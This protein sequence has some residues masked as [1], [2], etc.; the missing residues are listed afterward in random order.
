MKNSLLKNSITAATVVMVL[1]AGAAPKFN[2][3][4]VSNRVSS[5][6]KTLSAAGMEGIVKH[7]PGLP[8]KSNMPSALSSI[9][10]ST[11]PQM[12]KMGT[13]ADSN[14]NEEVLIYENF[15]LWTE[16]TEENPIFIGDIDGFYI[17]DTY[18]NINPEKM[19][20]GKIW[21][22]YGPCSAGGVCALAYPGVGGMIQIPMGNYSGELHISVRVK[23]IDNEFT[24]DEEDGLFTIAMC[25]A[26]W[27]NPQ[28]VP[29]TE[30]S[31]YYVDWEFIEK[32]GEWHEIEWTYM[33]SYNEDDCFMQFSTYSQMLIDDIKVTVN[34]NF[35]SMPNPLPASNFTLDGFTA[36]WSAAKNATEYLLTC[37]RDVAE[38]NEPGSMMCDFEGVN[39]T[40]GAI[41]LEDPNFPKGWEFDFNGATPR[42]LTPSDGLDSDALCMDT[43]GQAITSPST[44]APITDAVIRLRFYGEPDEDGYYEGTLGFSGWDG[45][46]WVG[47]GSLYLDEYFIDEMVDFYDITEGLEYNGGK[48]YKIR[49]DIQELLEGSYVAIDDININ[50]LPPCEKEYVVTELPVKETSYVFTGLDPY[51]DYYYQ[52]SARNPELGIESAAPT[53]CTYA[54]GLSTPVPLPASDMDK[55]DG[56]YTA[57]WEK[58]PK[59]QE[60]MVNTYI[61]YNAPEEVANYPVLTETFAKADLGFTVENPYAF[62][63]MQFISLDDFCDNPGWVGYLCGIAD[64]AVGGV[65]YP[66][67]GFGGEIQTPWLSLAHNDGKFNVVVSACGFND[68]I[69]CVV[70]SNGEGY[71]CPLTEDYQ[72]YELKFT[73]GTNNDFLAFYTQNKENFFINYVEVSQNLKKGDKVLYQRDSYTTSD[74]SYHIENEDALKTNYSAAYTITGVHVGPFDTAYSDFSEVTYVDFNT[75]AVEDVEASKCVSVSAANGEISVCAPQNA[76]VSVIASNGVKMAEFAG[77][78]NVKVPAGMYIVKVADQVFKIMVK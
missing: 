8:T 25:R 55:S 67:Y 23:V 66:F 19:Q 16:G 18:W 31:P 57:N 49:L 58:T 34:N 1:T 54:F 62:D 40:D 56:S 29:P 17:D 38:S 46:K 50:T 63:N 65:G 43:N 47:L 60:Y 41:N 76:E 70:N 53:S 73:T 27:F 64:H 12:N 10:K 39:N 59:A 32:D 9:K 72:K 26:P 21:G 3:S 30:E 6:S 48:F 2:S 69:L 45:Y 7:T 36:N 68:D 20:D 78:M 4:A 61:V 71:E 77:S 22:S 74:T 28:P 52:V 5:A 51:S 44:G 37:W 33:N 24:E 15:S 13:R 35:V 11:L 42:L 75:D 14:S